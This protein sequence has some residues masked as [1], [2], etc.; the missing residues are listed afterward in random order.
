MKVEIFLTLLTVFS[1]ANGLVVESVKKLLGD[2]Y[3]ISY[4]LVAVISGLIVGLCGTFLYYVLTDI[5][6]GYVESIFAVL[7]GIASA[8]SSMVGYDKI[9]QLVDQVRF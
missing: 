7:L 2:K 9:K 3:N 1:T 5:T 4:N 6:I 8:M